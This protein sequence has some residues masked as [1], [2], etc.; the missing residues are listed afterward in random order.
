MK[1]VFT[2]FDWL[3]LL[4]IG[5]CAG[6]VVAHWQFTKRAIAIEQSM[7]HTAYLLTRKSSDTIALV[8][9]QHACVLQL[10]DKNTNDPFPYD[11]LFSDV[12][13]K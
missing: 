5:G 10:S 13:T 9:R 3:V 11:T 7:C 1:R 12:P 4:T 6:Y 2:F 8:A